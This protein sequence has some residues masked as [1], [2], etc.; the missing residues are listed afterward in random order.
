MN[1]VTKT[2]AKYYNLKEPLGERWTPACEKAFEEIIEKLTSSPVLGLA[3]FKLPCILYTDDASTTGAV[4]YQEQDGRSRVIA[5]AGRGLSISDARYPLC[6]L[7][8][9]ALKCAI[10]EKM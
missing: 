10:T 3:N 9:L 8:F 2:N 7:E 1:Q 4:L 6:K 5:Y